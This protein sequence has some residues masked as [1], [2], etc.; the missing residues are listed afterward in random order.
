MA[1]TADNVAREYGITREQADAF[2]ARSQARYARALAEGFFAGEITPVDAA[3][4]AKAPPIVVSADEHPRPQ[5]TTESLA[6][7]RPLSRAA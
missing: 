5:S 4:A 7:L 1:Q 2:A 6:K 3:R